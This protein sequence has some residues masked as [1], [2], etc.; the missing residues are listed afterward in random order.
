MDDETADLV[1]Q[2]CTRAG[3]IMEDATTVVIFVGGKTPAELRSTVG[4][5]QILSD[6]VAAILAAAR[7]ITG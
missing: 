5:L 4:E 3:M 7:V 1:R 2:L 6:R